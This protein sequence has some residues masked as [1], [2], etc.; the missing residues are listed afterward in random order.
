MAT[1]WVKS[2][3]CKSNAL[4]DVYTPNPKHFTNLLPSSSCRKSVQNLKDVV[5][6]T[7]QKKKK[8]RIPPTAPSRSSSSS[9]ASTKSSSSRHHSKSSKSSISDSNPNTRVRPSSRI[10][11][12]PFSSSSSLTKLSEE[13]PSH[14]VVQIIFHTSWSPVNPFSGRIEMVFKVQ[15][16]PKTIS[17]FEEYREIVKSRAVSGDG[18]RCIAD[19]NEVMRFYC[20]GPTAGAIYDLG[21]LC[22]FTAKNRSICTY[23]GSGRAHE[24]LGGG[25]GT[26]AMLVCRVVAG[27]ICSRLGVESFSEGRIGFDSV[28]GDNGELFVFDARALLPCFLIIYKP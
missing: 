4:D 10:P 19:G 16:P 17:R 22:E 1:G 21:R 23:S 2:L 5:D 24:S 28:S 7:K 18:G 8:P 13:H 11:P 3:Q 25:K 14:N 26:R 27:R 20:I 12:D 6:S 9:T 15:N